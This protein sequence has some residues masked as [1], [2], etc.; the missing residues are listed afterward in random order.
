MR[1]KC[2]YFLDYPI[3]NKL[4]QELLLRI[5]YFID[6]QRP[7]CPTWIDG[8]TFRQALAHLANQPIRVRPWF[9]SSLWGGQWLKSVCKNLSESAKNYGWSFEMITS[10]N[11]LILSDVNNHLL[12]LSWDIFYGSQSD[13]ILGNDL[14]YRLFSHANHFPIRFNFLDTM[15]G[16]NLSLHTN[17]SLEYMRTNFGER[18]AQD[19][20]YYI[21]K[22]KEDWR[23]A[24][25][26]SKKPLSYIYLGFQKNT[27]PDEFY[28]AIF[29]SSVRKQDL[30]IEKYIQA[31][32]TNIHDFFL[33]P[34]QT[35][36][37]LG[38][39]QVAL[40]ISST[41]YI[42]SFKLYDWSRL[43]LLNIEH[44][45]KNLKF[46]RYGE[47][48]RCQSVRL[49]Y[50]ENKYEEQ[51]LPT[52][53]LHFYD[54]QRIIIEPDE[55]IQ[56]DRL[57]ENRFHLCMLVEGDAIEIEYNSIDNH[58]QKQ[59]RQYNY[60]ETFLIPASIKQYQIRPIIKNDNSEK[61]FILLVAFIKWDCEKLLE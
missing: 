42:Y 55:N 28:E 2:L 27:K 10:E 19:E 8:D 31:I 52:H 48:L 6:S 44:G 47:S 1:Q 49:K 50:E 17:P 20:T 23:D 60:I 59:I 43:S 24:Y 46:D 54:I 22:T 3:F 26:K 11:G 30:D 14:H 61:K 32:P 45:M 53:D 38:R 18:F 56:I 35:I 13:Q 5:N 7:N 9:E 25:R 40:E 16:G 37:S 33:I 57:T 41:P 29:L 51:H 58:Q 4:K 12:E 39:N 15:D 34:N 21:I 36:H